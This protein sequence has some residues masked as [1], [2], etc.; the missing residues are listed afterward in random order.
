VCAVTVLRRGHGGSVKIMAETVMLDGVSRTHAVPHSGELRRK[1]MP[2]WPNDRFTGTCR[3]TGPRQ[4]WP[5]RPPRPVKVVDQLPAGTKQARFNS[6]LAVKV[7]TGVGTMW[8]AYAFTALALVSLPSAIA[9][10]NAVTLVSWISQTFLQLV[11]LSVIIVGQN[12]LAAAADNRSEAT[13]NDADAV[14][15][16]AVMIQEHLG[17]QDKVLSALI[18]KAARRAWLNVRRP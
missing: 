7:T 12:V 4:G 18:D 17:A 6:W 9:S 15:H 1:G 8:C 5:G 10:H 2:S 3:T 14:L 13:Y 16:E 11:L